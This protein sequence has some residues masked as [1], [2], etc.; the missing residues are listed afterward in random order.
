MGYL[1]ISIIPFCE[2]VNTFLGIF[3]EEGYFLSIGERVLLC[4]EQSNKTQ[5][6]LARYLNTKQSTV[7]GWTK[8]GRSPTADVIIRICE[9]LNISAE[10][11]LTGKESPIAI[12]EVSEP[13]KAVIKKYRALDEHGKDIVDI[14]LEKEYGRIILLEQERQKKE[15]TIEFSSPADE[16][17]AVEMKVYLEKSAA[18][19]GNY[20]TGEG[21][22]EL[23]TFPS[24]EV[25]SRADFGIRISGDSMEPRIHDDEIVWVRATPQ[26]ES[27]EIGIFVLNEKALCKK[28]HIDY[29]KGRRTELISLN[30]KYKSIKIGTG[31]S[32]RTIGQVLGKDKWDNWS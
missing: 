11:L 7:L 2:A 16:P 6:E 12:T 29:D 19:I 28:L 13:H 31:D 9:F 27:G 21:E 14:V 15:K 8:L 30:T 25:P 32:L 5:A 3:K 4:L 18:G 1:V 23:L 24:D 17:Q 10:Y 20:L 26:I 22:Y